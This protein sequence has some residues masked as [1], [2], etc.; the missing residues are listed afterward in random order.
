MHSP[1]QYE[2]RPCCWGHKAGRHGSECRVAPG[3]C[4]VHPQKSMSHCWSAWVGPV[5]VSELDSVACVVSPGLAYG[6]CLLQLG[7]H[8]YTGGNAPPQAK[9]LN[10]HSLFAPSNVQHGW[11]HRRQMWW[12]CPDV[13]ARRQCLPSNCLLIRWVCHPGCNKQ[14]WARWSFFVSLWNAHSQSVVHS[15]ATPL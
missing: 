14:G 11:E 12:A 15:N 7:G 4:Q 13:G 10:L 3:C 6:D 2:K 9:L 8:I 1:A 5:C